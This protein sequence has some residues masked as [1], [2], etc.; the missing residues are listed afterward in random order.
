ML[1][2][3]CEFCGRCNLCAEQQQTEDDANG[4]RDEWE[5]SEAF[6]DATNPF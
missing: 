2:D 4:L 5:R 1:N 6:E 3:A